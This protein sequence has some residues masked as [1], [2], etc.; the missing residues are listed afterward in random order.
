MGISAFIFISIRKP[1][2][3]EKASAKLA[4]S[5]GSWLEE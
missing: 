1:L 3:K 4:F 5:L 2:E